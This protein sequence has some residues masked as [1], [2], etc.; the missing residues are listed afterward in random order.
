L[1][2]IQKNSNTPLPIKMSNQ[3]DPKKM[4]S[5]VVSTFNYILEHVLDFITFGN[6]G[7]K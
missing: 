4:C 7:T 3:T 2:Q 1:N 5:V 6:L